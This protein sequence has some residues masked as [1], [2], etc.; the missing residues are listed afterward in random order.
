MTRKLKIKDGIKV[1]IV[2]EGEELKMQEDIVEEV[3]ENE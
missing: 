2:R 3:E 1:Q